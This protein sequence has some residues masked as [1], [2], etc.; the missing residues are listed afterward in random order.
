MLGVVTHDL[1]E[2]EGHVR[3]GHSFGDGQSIGGPVVWRTLDD[4]GIPYYIGIADY[5]LLET[6]FEWSM[7][8][9]G[10]TILQVLNPVTLQW[11]DELN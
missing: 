8:D 10:T 9:A 1:L 5:E 11:K 6:I 7:G 2:I 4:D 3:K